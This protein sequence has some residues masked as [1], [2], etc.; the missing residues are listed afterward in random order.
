M[1][2]NFFVAKKSTTQSVDFVKITW[3]KIQDDY[4][5]LKEVE[6]LYK[7]VNA[8]SVVSTKKRQVKENK[9]LR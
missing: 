6:L 2:S 5:T 1:E 3:Q 4:R 9:A 7:D 8:T